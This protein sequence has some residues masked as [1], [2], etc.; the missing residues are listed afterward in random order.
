[1]PNG[2]IVW[3]WWLAA[4]LGLALGACDEEK[5]DPPP[6]EGFSIQGTVAGLT[7]AGLV[8]EATGQPD[9]A[10]AVG[11]TAFA[12]A[13]ALPAGT[14]YHVGV[15]TPPAGQRCTVANGDGT[16]T[17]DVTDVAVDCWG[18][19]PAGELA[20]A[21]GF[22]GLVR[23]PSG[24]VLAVGGQPSFTG[25]W[26]TTVTERWSPTTKTWSLAKPLADARNWTGDCVVLLTGGKVLAAGGANP[27]H[28]WGQT[29]AELYDPALDAWSPAAGEMAGVHEAGVCVLLGSG[30][31]LLGGGFTATG[32]TAASELFDPATGRFE[33]TGAMRQA[34]YWA[35]A[36]VLPSGKVLVAGGCLGTWPCVTSTDKAELY[37]PEAGT[38]SDAASLPYT[39]MTHT[40]TLLPS[41]KVLVAGGCLRYREEG[42]CADGSNDR[43]AALWDPAPAP[44]GTW[45]V[46]GSLQ[47]GRADHVALLLADGGVL[48]VGGGLWSGAGTRT[49]RYDVAT[50]TWADGP[51]TL[52]DHGNGL[53]A[54]KLLDG[55]WLLAG[56]AD[57][58]N[59]WTE[60]LTE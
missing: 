22:F 44:G 32:S 25:N 47:K 55:R 45:T 26:A 57:P 12:F 34:R 43:R 11:Q 60:L 48:V 27:Q 52:H 29:T 30:K 33:P 20:L 10:V 35:T 50:G 42:K 15:K 1:M 9:L 17:A 4:C 36:T 8:L 53:G 40:A 23:L 39:V 49:E 54:V 59:G 37:D 51:P 28:E 46:T 7:G 19:T 21:R 13:N 31:V 41:G 38:W 2:K 24:E 6:A 14:A 18:W 5:Q 16:A 56:G 3:T 58:Y